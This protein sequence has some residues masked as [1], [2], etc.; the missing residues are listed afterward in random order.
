MQTS[1][2]YT[3][4]LR[5]ETDDVVPSSATFSLDREKARQIIH[6]NVLVKANNLYRVEA[7][8][9]TVEYGEDFRTSGE[10]LSVSAGEFWFGGHEKYSGTSFET[11]RLSIAELAQHFGVVH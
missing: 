7:F 5:C 9:N 11:E 10:T 6:L 4:K 3:V 2:D 1:K 8:D